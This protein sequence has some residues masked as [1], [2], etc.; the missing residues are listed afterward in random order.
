MRTHTN[1]NVCHRKI[2]FDS[3]GAAEAARR[4]LVRKGRDDGSI[5]VYKCGK[6]YHLGH[7]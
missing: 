1:A 4:S 7:L 2:R 5:R 6:H 3:R